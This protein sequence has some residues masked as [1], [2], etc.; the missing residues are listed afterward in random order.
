M[1]CIITFIKRLPHGTSAIVHGFFEYG[2][3][4]GCNG[5]EILAG[6]SLS[7]HASIA[8]TELHGLVKLSVSKSITDVEA[9]V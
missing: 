3:I 9:S 7:L 1:E 4:F 5:L 6:T 8:R 2:F